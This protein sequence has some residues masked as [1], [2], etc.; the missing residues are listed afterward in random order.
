VILLSAIPVY[1]AQRIS[2]E[3]ADSAGG[4]ATGAAGDAR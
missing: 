3:P 4:M 1:S 2:Q